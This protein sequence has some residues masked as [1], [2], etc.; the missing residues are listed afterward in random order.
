MRNILNRKG[1]TFIEL[2]AASIIT[3]IVMI[4]FASMDISLRNAYEGTSKGTLV[5]SKAAAV[6][7]HISRRILEASGSSAD[8]GFSI[9]T[10]PDRLWIR[11]D[12]AAK[13]PSNY[14]DDS[15]YL[16]KHDSAASTITYCSTAGK[17]LD[18]QTTLQTFSNITTFT[19]TLLNDPATYQF[20]I[21]ILLT[22]RYDASSA[23]DPLANPEYTVTSTFNLPSSSST[24]P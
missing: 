20:A 6:M 2:L 11:S 18:C 1:I 21:S 17:N 7:H 9:A 23:A 3:G 24:I 8:T 15:W 13:T 12:G 5:A 19:P 4:G 22:S 14:S 16:Y 10:A